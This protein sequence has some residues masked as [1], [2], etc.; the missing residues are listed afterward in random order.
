MARLGNYRR[1]FGVLYERTKIKN[2]T[3]KLI[4]F[5]IEGS[6]SIAVV[7]QQLRQNKNAGLSR[8]LKLNLYPN[9]NLF[10]RLSSSEMW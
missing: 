1:H 9:L 2:I 5:G 10:Q 7:Q 3:Q 4:E 6:K 8:K